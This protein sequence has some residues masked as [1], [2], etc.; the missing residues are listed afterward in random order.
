[1]NTS[2]KVSAIFAFPKWLKYLAGYISD[3]FYNSE[4]LESTLRSAM[5]P[6]RKMFDVSLPGHAGC[7]VAITTS[8]TTDGKVCVFA[9]YRGVGRREGKFSYRFIVPKDTNE[10]PFLWEM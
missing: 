8:Q 6:T 9:N 10:N 7:R 4:N 1:V 2:K 5:D 3:S